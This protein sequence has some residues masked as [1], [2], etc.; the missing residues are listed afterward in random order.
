MTDIQFSSAM[1]TKS[2]GLA[3]KSEGTA[4]NA[5]LGYTIIALALALVLGLSA[6]DIHRS[7]PNGA[8]QLQDVSPTGLVLDGRGKW[9]GY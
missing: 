3:T 2:E 9:G 1:A 6:A 8:A 4:P 7:D 5:T